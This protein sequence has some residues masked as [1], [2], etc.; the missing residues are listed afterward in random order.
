MPSPESLVHQKIYRIHPPPVTRP[1]RER[2][3]VDGQPDAYKVYREVRLD[4]DLVLQNGFKLTGATKS[5]E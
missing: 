5:K 1:C 3:V 2:T 4:G